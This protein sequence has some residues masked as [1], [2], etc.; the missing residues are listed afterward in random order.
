[1]I[2]ISFIFPCKYFDVITD[3][4]RLSGLSR[5][6]LESHACWRTLWEGEIKC[7]CVGSSEAMNKFFWKFR[8]ITS[9]SSRPYRK[10]HT[11]WPHIRRPLFT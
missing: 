4:A 2:Y 5:S 9:S 3:P 11:S 7:Y 1:M 8:P 6:L 10:L